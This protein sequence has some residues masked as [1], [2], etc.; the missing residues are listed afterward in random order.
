MIF[1]CEII[2]ITPITRLGLTDPPIAAEQ[3]DE[4][5]MRSG[6]V[7][8]LEP[9]ECIMVAPLN[10]PTLD[11]FLNTHTEEPRNND[12]RKRCYW[13]HGMTKQVPG[14]NLDVYDICTKCG[15]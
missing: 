7:F 4:L 9:Y 5:G 6:I 15:R 11:L 14:F 1:E 8:H 2:K 12:G 3:L 10:E 13:C